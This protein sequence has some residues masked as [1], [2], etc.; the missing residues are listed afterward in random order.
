MFPATSL[1]SLLAVS[2][3]NVSA[4]YLPRQALS[5]RAAPWHIEVHVLASSHRRVRVSLIYSF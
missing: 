4:R 5:S 2:K 3:P 1:N